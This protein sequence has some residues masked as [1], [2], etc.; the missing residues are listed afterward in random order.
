MRWDRFQAVSLCL[1]LLVM[2]GGCG[3]PSAATLPQE[4]RERIPTVS[5]IHPERKAVLHVI[6]QPAFIEAYEETPVIARVPGY[7]RQVQVDI[8]DRVKGPRSVDQGKRLE[9][10]QVLAELRVPEMEAELRQKQALVAQAV[11]EV[12]QNVSA[13]EAAEA[14]ILTMKAMVGEAEAARARAQANYA[15]WESEYQRVAGLVERRVIDEQTRDET[16]N[17]F[18]AADAA[19][20]EVEARVLSARAGTKESEAKRN[21]AQADLAA[22]RARVEVAKAEEGRLA[23]LLSYSELRAPFDGVVVRR[24]I[25][26]GHYLQPASGNGMQPVFVIARTDIV[27]VLVDVPEMDAPFVREGVPAR[28]RIPTIKDQEFEG[29]VTRS[30]WSL[31]P[32]TRTLRTEI[33]LANPQGKLRP[34]MYAYVSLRAELPSTFTLPVSAVATQGDQSFCCQVVEGQA[35]RVPLKIGIRSGPVVQVLKKQGRPA[36]WEDLTGQEEIALA[37]PGALA[38]GQKVNVERKP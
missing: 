38:D 1:G 24:N 3:K 28:V 14:N 13:V 32:K 30:S 21:R 2:V 27:R 19:R 10:G 6:E 29:K 4:P 20:A 35:Y 18:K 36:A 33:H 16:R 25:H 22:A 37:N 17:Q 9:P 5:T 26:T 34:G 15:R 7:V 12:E 11:A 31:D 8:G 23:A